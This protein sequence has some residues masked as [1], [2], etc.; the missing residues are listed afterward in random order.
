MVNT[1]GRGGSEP[2]T[3]IFFVNVELV[4]WY[5]AEV[6]YRSH[7]CNYFLRLCRMKIVAAILM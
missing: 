2:S 3:L 4:K 7:F 5:F 6:I 1:E